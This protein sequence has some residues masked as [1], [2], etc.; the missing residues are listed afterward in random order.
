M[1]EANRGGGGAYCK[2][3]IM[4]IIKLTNGTEIEVTASQQAVITEWYFKDSQKIL[5]I[6]GHRFKPIE[7]VQYAQ[8]PTNSKIKELEAQGYDVS[9]YKR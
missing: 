7:V 5:T 6:K 1:S 8:R 4:T 3:E 2:G 9:W